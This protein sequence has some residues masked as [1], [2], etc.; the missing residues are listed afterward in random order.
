MKESSIIDD[1]NQLDITPE[2]QA[3]LDSLIDPDEP[4]DPMKTHL[5]VNDDLQQHI[6]GSLLID[7]EFLSE[8][9]PH[10]RSGLFADHGLGFLMEAAK[11]WREYDPQGIPPRFYIADQI[12]TKVALPSDA[13]D[14]EKAKA[15]AEETRRLEVYDQLVAD[16]KPEHIAY[17][18]GCLME[19]VREQTVRL[20]M[21]TY[22][23]N[24]EKKVPDAL[25][26][27]LAE[28]QAARSIGT[29]ADAF[30]DMVQILSESTGFQWLIDDLLYAGSL[31][32]LSGAPGAGKTVWLLRLLTDFIYGSPVFRDK[33]THPATVC[34]L[35]Y[36]CNGEHFRDNLRVA[37]G[38]RDA[39]LARDKFQ[40]ATLGVKKS[41]PQV[42]TPAYLDGVVKKYQPKIVVV[43]PL[44][45]A[46]AATPKLPNG[47]END[48]GTMTT[49]LAPFR[50]WAHDNSVAVIFIHHHN[51]Q[52]GISGSAAIQACSDV[53]WNFDR[54]EGGTVATVK[55]SK[56][57]PQSH[58]SVWEYENRRYTMRAEKPVVFD[59]N[60]DLV[61]AEYAQRIWD[62]LPASGDQLDEIGK[63]TNG[64]RATVRS[65]VAAL[66]E[67]GAI[68]K[69]SERKPY[70]RL[71]EAKFNSRIVLWQAEAAKQGATA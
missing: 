67:A 24:R 7:A 56:R 9:A 69:P 37:L 21:K 57:L 38:G 51:K 22:L 18:R 25:D 30:M 62:K 31:N 58:S 55:I 26:K 44:R 70:I 48:S 23:D 29:S 15:K 66:N 46:F 16:T 3:I 59:K 40:Y 63:G 14:E 6:V 35:D 10:L 53:L 20:A 50:Q 8:A 34:W 64:G 49:L 4:E 36:D 32:V 61:K 45:A 28:L 39:E 47:W 41:L 27:Y 1:E 13:K 42:L 71:D 19:F 60:A 5:P 2:Q 43:D 33:N 17:C 52:G 11:K 54:P 65:V 68:A 12:R